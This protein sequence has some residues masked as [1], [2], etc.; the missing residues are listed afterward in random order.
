MKREVAL[1]RYELLDEAKPGPFA[2]DDRAPRKQG[3]RILFLEARL[4]A[5][6]SAAAAQL[7]RI[8]E[9]SRKCGRPTRGSPGSSTHHN[10]PV[11]IAAPTGSRI[12]AR[13]QRRR[14]LPPGGVRR[15]KVGKIAEIGQ[16]ATMA[17]TPPTEL[18]LLRAELQHVSPADFEKLVAAL[19]GNLIG[20]SVVIAKSGFQHGA[21]AGT[22]GRQGR[23]L[24][25]ETKRYSDT[26]PL[27]ERELLGELEQAC[28]RDPPWSC[29]S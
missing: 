3:E 18:N 21:D 24:R 20:V 11:R 26:N 16:D 29:G 6:R 13:A 7:L 4:T 8:E 27:G 10:A 9:L 22:A 28:Q 17:S 12:G 5:A 14:S 25:V 15:T 1:K 2:H 23:R 19:V